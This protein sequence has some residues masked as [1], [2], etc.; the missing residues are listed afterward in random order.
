M[1]R[2]FTT[3]KSLPND[4]QFNANSTEW[5]ASCY[6]DRWSNTHPITVRGKVRVEANRRVRP[7]DHHERLPRWHLRPNA[8]PRHEQEPDNPTQ[9]MSPGKEDEGHNACFGA[10]VVAVVLQL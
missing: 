1:K 5:H 9:R 10:G 6:A 4:S 8:K 7:S 3:L 2:G